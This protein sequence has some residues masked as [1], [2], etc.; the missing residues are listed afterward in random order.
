MSARAGGHFLP[1]LGR[2]A[3]HALPTQS[4][5]LPPCPGQVSKLAGSV[6]A[7]V[8]VAG[9]PGPT[10]CRKMIVL[11]VPFPVRDPEALSI[12]R[13][14]SIEEFL[15]PLEQT[16]IA[17]S[18]P[19]DHGVA[20]EFVARSVGEIAKGFYF[21]FDGSRRMFRFLEG[22]TRRKAA[23]TT[24]AHWTGAI[25]VRPARRIGRNSRGMRS[26]RP[27]T[28]FPVDR[29]HPYNPSVAHVRDSSL[30]RD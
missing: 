28:H 15:I 30:K 3:G 2:H 18:A 8:G 21:R 5:T 12:A 6:P 17:G 14:T 9:P 13:E 29:R 19:V 11:D 26:P 27:C 4:A 24:P 22:F 7:L 1:A 10:L 23:E 25:G 20:E 16:P